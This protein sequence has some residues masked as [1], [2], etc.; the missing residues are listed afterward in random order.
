MKL[1][2]IAGPYSAPTAWQRECNIRAAEA[3]CL[4]LWRVGVPAVCV[5]TIARHY[6]DEVPEET[7]IAI[8]NE[9]LRRCDAVLLCPGW[10]DSKGTLAEIDL[11]AS[12]GKPVFFPDQVADCIAWATDGDGTA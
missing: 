6:H 9:I 1:I 7:A 5:H 11:A 2:Y 3:Q 10:Q 4:K 8:D 12:L